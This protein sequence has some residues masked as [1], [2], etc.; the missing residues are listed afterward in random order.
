[1]TSQLEL[2]HRG[3]LPSCVWDTPV[4]VFSSGL[5]LLGIAGLAA[6]LQAPNPRTLPTLSSQGQAAMR[7]QQFERAHTALRASDPARSPLRT[8][9]FQSWPRP[10]HVKQI[11]ARDYRVSESAGT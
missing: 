7:D 6:R 9:P 4:S 1:M 3:R 11:S 5:I 10:L 8:G 2:L